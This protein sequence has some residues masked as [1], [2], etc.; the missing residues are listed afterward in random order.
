MILKM[1]HA[2]NLIK[3][4]GPGCLVNRLFLLSAQADPRAVSSKGRT[5]L[6]LAQ[7]RRS[8]TMIFEVWLL[9][10]RRSFCDFGHGQNMAKIDIVHH[11]TIY[12]IL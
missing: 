1:L 11:I 3:L 4:P 9:G 7:D 8:W 6:E 5:A 2:L 10:F 12:N